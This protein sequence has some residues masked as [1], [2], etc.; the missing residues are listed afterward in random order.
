MTVCTTSDA[1][2]DYL[3]GL[4]QGEFIWGR[5][6]IDDKGGLIGILYASPSALPCSSD[7]VKPAHLSRFYLRRTL[8]L[9]VP[10]FWLSVL[11]KRLA[12]CKSVIRLFSTCHVIPTAVDRVREAY[13]AQWWRNMEK[14]RWPYLWMRVV[15]AK[16]VIKASTHP[17]NRRVSRNRRLYRCYTRYRRERISGYQS[18]CLDCWW[19]FQCSASPYCQFRCL[20]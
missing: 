3:L 18:D 7:N 10:S 17:L 15:S 16:Y 14:T 1:M 12:A 8:S 2:L 11:M 6:C 9:L 13:P 4:P 19:P 20:L 5:G